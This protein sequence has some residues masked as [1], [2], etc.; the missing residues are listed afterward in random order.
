MKKTN[1][2]IVALVFAFLLGACEKGDQRTGVE[3]DSTRQTQTATETSTAT[4]GEEGWYLS[5]DAGL[6][7]AA[8]QKKPVLAY[9]KA[10]WCQF[11]TL[12]EKETF[13]STDIGQTLASEWIAIRLDIDK[14]SAEGIYRG[15]RL[16]YAEIAERFGIKAL[17]SFVFLDK[18]SDPV[19]VISGYNSKQ[20]FGIILDYMG[21]EL[22]KD[23][24]DLEVYI[25]TRSSSTL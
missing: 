18:Q 11:C 3:R 25:S 14:K 21:K 24:V 4:D 1:C 8:K 6:E 19:R 16:T 15:E 17:P 7:T 23:N 10:P 12:M 20:R 13:S 9:F 2:F 5:W 22:Y